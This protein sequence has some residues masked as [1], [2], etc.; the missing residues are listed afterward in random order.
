[1]RLTEALERRDALLVLQ[2][3]NLGVDEFTPSSQTFTY[4]YRVDATSGDIVASPACWPAGWA[5][6]R[7]RIATSGPLDFPSPRRP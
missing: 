4:S 7:S 5:S 3:T 1:L 6:G 2:G